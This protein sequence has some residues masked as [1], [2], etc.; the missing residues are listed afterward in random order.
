MP[1]ILS[2]VYVSLI[3]ELVIV[4]DFKCI[5]TFITLETSS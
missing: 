3:Q 4:A 2:D 5:S 1:E